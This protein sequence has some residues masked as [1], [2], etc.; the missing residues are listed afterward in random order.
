MDKNEQHLEHLA[1]IRALMDRSSRFI[2]L[3]GLSGVSAGIFALLGVIAA[4][5]YFNSNGLYV[6]Q[7]SYIPHGTGRL[8]E[9]LGDIAT[10]GGRWAGVGVETIRHWSFLILD[11]LIVLILALASAFFFTARKAKR[12]GLRIWDKVAFRMIVNMAIPLVT[13]G[14]FCLIL[15]LNNQVALIAPATLIFYGLAAFNAGKYTL[16][17]IRYLGVSEI[18]LGLIGCVVPGYGLFIWAIGFGVLHIVYGAMM[19]FRYDYK[20]A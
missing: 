1:E 9:E 8:S 4:Y 15:L 11:G 12:L 10:R 13:G 5:W 20:A 2:S 7:L 3:S 18:I 17:E 6:S 19:Y 16:D 14:L